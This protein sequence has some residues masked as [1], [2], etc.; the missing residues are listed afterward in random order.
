MGGKKLTML[1]T[2]SR[3]ICV[4]FREDDPDQME[5]WK[6]LQNDRGTKTYGELIA[7]LIKSKGC[8][9][10]PLHGSD[11]EDSPL[12]MDIKRIC[13]DIRE[14][15]DRCALSPIG[16]KELSGNTA[17]EKMTYKGEIPSGISDLMRQLSGEDE[18]E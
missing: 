10:A 3:T 16:S 6:Y 11:Y 5:A 7:E 18:D 1:G 2:K 4:K 17:S 12:L 9:V 8:T 13:L 14:T 15:I